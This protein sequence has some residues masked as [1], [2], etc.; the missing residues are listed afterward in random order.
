[1]QDPNDWN[2]QFYKVAIYSEKIRELP[3]AKDFVHVDTKRYSGDAA[4]SFAANVIGS[5]LGTAGKAAIGAI[6]AGIAVSTHSS[7]KEEVEKLITMSKNLCESNTDVNT[8]LEMAETLIE[9]GDEVRKMPLTGT[10]PNLYD[11]VVSLS[12]AK[13]DQAGREQ[14]IIDIRNKAAG[15][16]LLLKG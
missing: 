11:A 16:S 2:A 6:G 8:Y 3:G 7:F 1:M 15:K 5:I 10:R 14:D 13:L 12:T 4:G 9:L